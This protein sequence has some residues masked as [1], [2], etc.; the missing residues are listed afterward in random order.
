MK[1]REIEQLNGTGLVKAVYTTIENCRW[2]FGNDGASSNIAGLAADLGINVSD[3]VMVS[4]KHTDR[5]KAVD[6]GNGGEMITFAPDDNIY[7]GMITDEKNLLLCTL[8]AD[9][10]PVYILDPVR[11]AIGMVHSGWRG[12]ASNIAVNAVRLMQNKYN[13]SPEDIMIVIG[14]H[15]CASCYEVGSELL[16]DF[17]R[18]YDSSEISRFFINRKGDKYHLDMTE[19]II[20]SLERIGVKAENIYDT[21]LCTIESDFLCSWRRDNPVMRSMLTGIMLI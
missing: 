4:Q 16:N 7:D 2:K 14:P 5:I 17:S 1:F 19:A 10:V 8:E 6:H 9:C 11:K 21:G 18:N 20:I 15:A 12:T 3:M 13:S